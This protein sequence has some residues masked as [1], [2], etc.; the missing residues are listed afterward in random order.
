ML[1]FT[2]SYKKI[3]YRVLTKGLKSDFGTPFKTTMDMW[4]DK[5]DDGKFWQVWLIKNNFGTIGVCGLYGINPGTDELW[6]G[7]LGLLPEMRN[8]GYGKDVMQF[9]YKEA[10]R[11]NCKKIL[12]YV[13]H[14]GKPLNFYY[15]EGFKNIGT[16]ADYVKNNKVDDDTF[17]RD[18]DHIITKDL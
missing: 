1:E 15:R 18:D 2:Q 6:L 7:W 5:V 10:K 8:I 14:A 16:V 11:H 13:D 4:C 3:D 17:E 9:I 12:S